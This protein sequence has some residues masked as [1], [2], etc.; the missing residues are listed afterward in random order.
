M[1]LWKEN[2]HNRQKRTGTNNLTTTKFNTQKGTKTNRQEQQPYETA[3]NQ[4]T[5]KTQK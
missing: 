4:N 5:P 1:Q 2:Y 3:Y